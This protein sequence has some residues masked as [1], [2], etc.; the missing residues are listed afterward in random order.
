MLGESNDKFSSPL[1][2]SAPLLLS[3]AFSVQFFHS[4][5]STNCLVTG[6]MRASDVQF[7]KMS[8]H[9]SGVDIKGKMFTCPEGQWNFIVTGP[10][11][12]TT[13]PRAFVQ[14]NR[15]IMKK[16]NTFVAIVIYAQTTLILLLQHLNHQFFLVFLNCS[17][18]V[19]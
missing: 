6:F 17:Y 2:Y 10:T 9:T 19:Y 12:V 14:K 3:S 18:L 1:V 7:L 11:I 16:M 13:G 4:V 15:I 8:L 5:Y